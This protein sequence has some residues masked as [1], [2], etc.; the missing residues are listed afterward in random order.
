LIFS[1]DIGDIVGLPKVDNV[2]D[3]QIST[4]SEGMERQ[5]YAANEEV[6]TVPPKLDNITDGHLST[7]S[8]AHIHICSCLKIH[9]L[10]LSIY[11]LDS[12]CVIAIVLLATFMKYFGRD[13]DEIFLTDGYSP[14]KN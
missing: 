8:T 5:Y 3:G 6:V 10:F 7:V 12:S 4:A 13:F 11:R 9:I 2:E 14:R 1:A